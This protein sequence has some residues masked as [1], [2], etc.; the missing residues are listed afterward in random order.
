M[1]LPTFW[2][3]GIETN[4][5]KMYYITGYIVPVTVFGNFLLIVIC[6]LDN[7]YIAT[8]I[9]YPSIYNWLYTEVW[10]PPRGSLSLIT[11]LMNY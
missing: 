1:Y 10:K 11:I 9:I 6:D 4:I 5:F 2:K 3:L 8:W 7:S